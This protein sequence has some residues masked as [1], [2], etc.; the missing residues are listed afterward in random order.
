MDLVRDC[1]LVQ[2]EDRAEATTTVPPSLTATS[3]EESPGVLKGG[4]SASVLSRN[5]SCKSPFSRTLDFRVLWIKSN[6]SNVP[7]I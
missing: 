4:H 3:D 6:S 1:A 7:L 5:K 2:G